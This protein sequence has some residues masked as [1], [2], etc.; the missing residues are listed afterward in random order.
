M[1][2]VMRIQVAALVLLLA[3]S[4]FAQ[5]ELVATHG[6]GWREN[7]DGLT[8]V[9][10]AGTPHQIGVQHGILLKDEIHFLVKYFFEDKGSL[11]GASV[12][13]IRKSAKLLESNI[14][15]EYIQEMKGVAEGSGI[16]YEKILMSNIFLDVVSAHWVGVGPQ[17]SNFI[18]LPEATRDGNIVHGR[19]LDWSADP[20]LAKLN[21]VFIYNPRGGITFLALGWPS[22]VGTL[23]G[24]NAE[25]MT[26]GEMTSVTSDATLNGTPIMI[27]LRMLI[28]RSHNLD[29]AY[30]ILKDTPRTTG[31]NVVVADGK[32]A[33]AFFAEQSASDIFRGSAKKGLIYHTNHYTHPK[34]KKKQE[35]YFYIIGKGKESDTYYRYKR[36][37]QLLE[38]YHGDID[39]E[40]GMKIM[41]DNFDI[42]INGVPEPK[43]MNNTVCKK[44]TM[45]S[46]IMLPQSGEIYLAMKG[47]PSPKNGYVKFTFDPSAETGE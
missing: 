2:A 15:D 4:G 31:Y 22:I 44:N 16:D 14:P 47:I 28:E 3:L 9:H 10:L 30:S 27:Q 17:C 7:V 39:A 33:D 37:G 5:A 6:E 21:T 36:L 20:D 41:S 1:K 13:D 34:M 35:K 45:Q 8:V 23:T 11:F 18:A 19:N 42:A 29:E 24:M 25:K 26:V 38:E 40:A 43:N 46:A 12:D 32:T